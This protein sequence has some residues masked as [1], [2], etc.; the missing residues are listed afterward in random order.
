MAGVDS[1]HESPLG[2]VGAGPKHEA[3]EKMEG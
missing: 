2:Q 3:F 1:F